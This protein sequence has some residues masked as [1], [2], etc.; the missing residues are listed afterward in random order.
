MIGKDHPYKKQIPIIYIVL[1]DDY[2]NSYTAKKNIM[3]Y[4]KKN[5]SYYMIP[6]EYYFR[7]ELPK[8]MIG[9]IDYHKLENEFKKDVNN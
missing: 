5:L 7:D 6:K 2:K 8:T 4:A 1:E 9:K 3:D